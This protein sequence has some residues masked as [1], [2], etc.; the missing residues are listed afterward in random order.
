MA[1]GARGGGAET[2]KPHPAFNALLAATKGRSALADAPIGEVRKMMAERAATRVGA[3]VAEVRDLYAPGPRGPIPLR[4][5]RPA[6]A[7]GVAV[8]FHGGGWMTGGLDTFDAVCRN[9]ASLS[10]AAVVSVDYR[11]APEFPFPAAVEDAWA[12]TQWV[13]DHGAE[14]GVASDRLA[15]FGESAGGNLAAVVALMARDA[16]APRVRRQILV[17][18]AVD[19]RLKSP[20]LDRFAEGYLQTKKDVVYAFKT[21]ALSAGVSPEDW[22]LSPLLAASHAGVAP[23]LILSAECD[24]ISDDSAAYTQCLLDAGVSAAHVQYAG[25]IHTFFAMRGIVDEADIAQAQ[26]AQEIRRA[27]SSA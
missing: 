2:M 4:L 1:S 6:G 14:L 21:Y 5:Y 23:A 27:F 18:P 13:A 20:S 17:Y 16:G 25:M 3:A 8:A 22:R 10:G 11:L 24:A 12:A 26:A 7:E 9:L 15:L 19:A